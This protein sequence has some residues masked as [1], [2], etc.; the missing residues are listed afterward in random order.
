[1]ALILRMKV[2]AMIKSGGLS[3]TYS[4][5]KMM[6]TLEKMK[7]TVTDNGRVFYSESTKKQCEILDVFDIVPKL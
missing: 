6:L 2:I 7:V 5:E 3:K 1:L 4:F